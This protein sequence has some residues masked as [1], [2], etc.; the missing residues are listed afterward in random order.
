MTPYLAA[1]EEYHRTEVPEIPWTTALDFHLQHG[2][3][4]SDTRAFLMARPVPVEWHDDRHTEL[5]PFPWEGGPFPS[6]H[7]WSAAG[8]LDRILTIAERYGAIFASFQRRNRRVHRATI[9]H[10]RR[11]GIARG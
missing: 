3:V 1:F 10:L 11:T 2:V 6:W 9:P 8:D 5:D 4:I 7:I